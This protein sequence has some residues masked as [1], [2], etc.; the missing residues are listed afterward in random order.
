MRAPTIAA[1]TSVRKTVAP[2]MRARLVP[3][4]LRQAS[5]QMNGNAASS[6]SGQPVAPVTVGMPLRAEPPGEDG[7]LDQQQRTREQQQQHPQLRAPESSRWL[8]AYPHCI[9]V[10]QTRAVDQRV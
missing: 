8:P 7:P 6:N 1:S 9:P 4:R 3:A 2:I 5:S 10:I